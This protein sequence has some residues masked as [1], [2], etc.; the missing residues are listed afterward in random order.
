MRRGLS[1]VL[2][3]AVMPV[4]AQDRID[5]AIDTGER[6]TRDASRSQSRI[7]RLADET[8]RKLEAYRQAIWER[9]QLHV[10]GEKLASLQPLQQQD[11]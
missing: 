2:A 3:L 5:Q 9:Q 7:D 4:L 10:Y 6:T 11:V 8:R 1:I